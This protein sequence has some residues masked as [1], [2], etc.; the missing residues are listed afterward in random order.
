MLFLLLSILFMTG[1]ALCFAGGSSHQA[2]P[3]G[4]NAVCR[5]TG[6]L[7]ALVGLLVLQRESDFTKLTA[8]LNW[9]SLLA[10]VFYWLAGYGAIQ[11]VRLGHLGVTWTVTRC[12]VVLPVL[13]S[14]LF[15]HEMAL[16][17][18]STPLLLRGSGLLLTLTAMVMVGLDRTRRH[19]DDQSKPTSRA[20]VCWLAVTFL[21]QGM[22]ETILRAS[23]AMADDAD[24]ACFI[25]VVF[26]VAAVLSTGAW[27]LQRPRIGAVEIRFGMLAGLCGFLGSGL[28]PWALRD[29]PGIVVFPVTAV[30]VML[31]VQAAGSVF[32]GHRL[33]KWGRAA[34]A[35]A[36]AAIVCL[37]L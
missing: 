32:W 29:L 7:L 17:P 33:G 34:M 27:V 10:G 4:L 1:M 30:S 19:P 8:Q 35:A 26:L 37:T 9:V 25:V 22:W 28:R 11:A 3:L 36:T 5:I 2:H 12:S 31:L 21:G 20:W 18:V 15:W 6:G 16:W 23:G 13:A 24:R 14:L